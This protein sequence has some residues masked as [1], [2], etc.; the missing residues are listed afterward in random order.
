[1]NQIV[2]FAAVARPA[3]LAAPPGALRRLWP[4]LLAHGGFRI[5]LLLAL[6]LL[7]LAALGPFIA[8][9]E[10]NWP[11]YAASLKAPGP[12]HWL[13]T[14]ATGRDVLSRLLDGAHRS[15]GAAVLVLGT[16]FVIGLVVG[17]IAGLAGGIVDTVLMR[18][19]DVMMTLPGLVLAFA[20]IGILGP[21][22]L[23][24]LF[25]LVIADWAYYARLSRALTLSARQR[26][27]VVAARMAGIG[28]PRILFGH[29][30][31]GV[32]LQ[33]AVVATLGMGGMIAAISGF[34]FLGLGVQP[35]YAE[36]G[37]M[38]AESRFYFPIAPWLLL[39]P[40]AT[41]FAS[42]MASNLIGNGLRDVLE[43]RGRS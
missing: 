10:P 29:I 22:F 15:I 23:N 1:M 28:W 40:A 32:A 41:I 17:T 19:V 38:L 35:P 4:R 36:W 13:G 3:P 20:I 31:P 34:S 5:G 11:D 26:P 8:P 21:G 14:D 9:Y 2:R 27:D 24:L 6:A 12:A 25:A 30:L 39:A 37:A 33:L 16:I 43:P 42:V 18:L 7:T